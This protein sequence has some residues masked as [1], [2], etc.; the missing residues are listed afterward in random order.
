MYGQY[1]EYSIGGIF[2]SMASIANGDIENLLVNPAEFKDKIIYIGTS[3]AGLQD[4]KQTSL[5]LVPGV[6]IHATVTSNILA[7]DFMQPVDAATTILLIVLVAGLTVLGILRCHHVIEQI[8][9]PLGLV[10][11]YVVWATVSFG[12]NIA[13]DVIPPVSAI[14][15]AWLSTMTF[16][17]FTEGKDKRKVRRMLS[18]YVSKA[19]LAEVVDKYENTISTEIGRKERVSVLFSDIREFTNIAESQEPE[20]VVE[21]L[22]AHLGAMSDVIINGYNGTLD[23]FIGDAIM[24]FWGAPIRDN[25]HPYQAVEAALA[26]YRRLQEVNHGL[27]EKGFPRIEIGI[28]IH[29]GDVVLGNIGSEQ[30]LDY[31][32]IGDSV[33][34]ASRMEGLT[35][36]YHCPILI[37]EATR[38]VVEDR[39]PCAIVD[40]VRVKGK[41]EAVGIYM[42]LV[43]SGAKSSDRQAA[44]E[45]AEIAK[46]AFAAYL[47][48]RWKQAITC[49]SQLPESDWTELAIARCRSYQRKAPVKSWD[50]ISTLSSK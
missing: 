44:T 13:F 18:Q 14:I 2:S 30:K 42:P 31:T 40:L 45:Q 48:R 38:N 19:V 28:G 32:I 26:M 29:T 37:S 43:S 39:I 25:D 12:F 8:A 50:G 1:Q 49:Y 16:L 41:Q 15:L 9:I 11:L 10:S 6:L 7:Q 34:L 47:S 5:G 3:A 22:N 4:I 23:K 27:E 21:I 24:A 20:E 46:A 17:T 35:K 36:Q 33:N